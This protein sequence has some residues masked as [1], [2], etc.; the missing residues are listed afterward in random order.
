[1]FILF[2]HTLIVKLKFAEVQRLYQSF[3]WQKL[4]NKSFEYTDNQK[5]LLAKKMDR[6]NTVV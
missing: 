1:M 2:K 4:T 5:L 3:I 6:N